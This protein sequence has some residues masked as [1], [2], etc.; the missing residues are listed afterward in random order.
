MKGLRIR[1]RGPLSSLSAADRAQLVDRVPA[2]DDMVRTTSEAIIDVVRREGDSAL[3][4]LAREYDNVRLKSVESV[5]C[6]S[7]K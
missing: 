5:G 1:F 7:S 4:S 3:I 6:F 2:T